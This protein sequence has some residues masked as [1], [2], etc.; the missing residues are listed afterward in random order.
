M[1]HSAAGWRIDPPVSVPSDSGAWHPATAAALPPLEPPGMRSTSHG[2]RVPWNALFSVDEPIANSSMF[3]L[4]NTTASAAFSRSTASASYGGTKFASILLEQVVRTPFVQST[5]FTATGTPA[6]RPSGAPLARFSSTA[7]AAARTASGSGVRVND[8]SFGSR[9]AAA[10][11]NASA[12]SS[13]LA[14]PAAWRVSS[15]AAVLSMR[16]M[17]FRGRKS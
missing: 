10:A 14:C 4:P 6:S 7:F 15:S 5:S 11:R 2:L 12:M 17:G 16:D 13:A 3:V 9:A 1:P 8:R